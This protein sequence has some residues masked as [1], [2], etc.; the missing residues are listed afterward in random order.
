[1][2]ST[3]RIAAAVGLAA[4]LTGL[5]APLAAAA[6]APEPGAATTNPLTALDS[7]ATTGV[8]ADRQA[9]MPRPSDQLARL[10]QLKEMAR[11]QQPRQVKAVDTPVTRMLPALDV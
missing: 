5:A 11:Q 1:M 7:L 9:A 2:K 10:D 3:R 4:G 8:P 6:P